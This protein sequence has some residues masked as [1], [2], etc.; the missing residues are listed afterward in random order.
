MTARAA[1]TSA[2]KVGS[3]PS[4]ERPWPGRSIASA[5]R[6]SGNRRCTGRQPLRS[7]PK[8]CR[9]TTG[10]P[11]PRWSQSR[12]MFDAVRGAGRRFSMS[13]SWTRPRGPDPL[14]SSSR[15]PRSRAIR[16]AAGVARGRASSSGAKEGRPIGRPSLDG[17]SRHS[18]PAG[19]E[20][21]GGNAAPRSS[22]RAVRA[23]TE[24][25][26]RR[27]RRSSRCRR[28]PAARRPPMRRRT[29]G[30][31]KPARRPPSPPCRSRSRTAVAP[32]T[33]CAPSA[34]CQRPI[35]PELMS[36]STRGMT[37]STAMSDLCQRQT[38]RRRDNVLGLRNGGLLQNRAIGNRRLDAAEPHD[39]RVE[40]V[41]RLAF[42]DDRRDFRPDA[43]RLDAFVDGE[44]PPCRL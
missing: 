40:I 17:L 27:P 32:L 35:R 9:N 21:P 6:D 34:A 37:I 42:G 16:R 25:S 20:L 24:R 44:Q 43:E 36:M 7:A 2:P 31:P 28:R 30:R 19:E 33:T 41:E 5:G 14:T 4:G 26:P 12:W 38:P 1:S 11:A 10:A 23:Q 22:G 18:L 15:N 8:P 29:S 13:R 3:L 39:R